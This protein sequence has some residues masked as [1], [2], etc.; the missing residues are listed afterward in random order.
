M[1]SLKFE[2]EPTERVKV[3]NTLYTE[4]KNEWFSIEKLACRKDGPEKN[5]F[6]GSGNYNIKGHVE[7]L[8]PRGSRRNNES[9]FELS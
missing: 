5:D 2:L 1:V 4:R 7:G 9:T 6:I 3:Q 8:Y